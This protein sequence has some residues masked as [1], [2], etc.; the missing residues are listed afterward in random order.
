MNKA[1][2]LRFHKRQ[3]IHYL[4]EQ[5]SAPKEGLCSM[6]SLITTVV[7]VINAQALGGIPF[8]F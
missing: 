6:E 8:A 3:Q 1:M 2:N 5:P 7:V 4:A